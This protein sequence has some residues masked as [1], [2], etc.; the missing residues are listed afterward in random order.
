MTRITALD[1]YRKPVLPGGA[2]AMLPYA[3]PSSEPSSSSGSS[4]SDGERSFRPGA[5]YVEDSACVHLQIRCYEK[6]Q[7]DCYEKDDPFGRGLV[8]RADFS[9]H[10]SSEGRGLGIPY[11]RVLR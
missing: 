7:G 3:P 11:P 10:G 5:A 1:P 2:F 8:L 9:S 6:L 4:A